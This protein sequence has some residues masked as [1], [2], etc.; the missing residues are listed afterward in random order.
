MSP[1]LAPTALLYPLGGA[2]LVGLGLYGM[3]ARA[4]P[5]RRLIGFNIVGS[6]LFVVFGATGYRPGLGPDPVP[7]A[8]IITGIVVAF[9]ATA[10]VTALIARWAAL[11]GSAGLP[12]DAARDA[13]RPDAERSP[14]P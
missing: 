11:A 14:T 5:M 3:I 8:L 10:L 4:H 1:D 12:E 13:R 6:G 2:A 7:Q 9:A